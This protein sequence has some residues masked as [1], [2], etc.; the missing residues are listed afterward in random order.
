[1]V[2]L[3][4]CG[5]SSARVAGGSTVA[6]GDEPAGAPLGTWFSSGCHDARGAPVSLKGSVVRLIKRADGRV[7]LVEMRPAYDSI[8]V[9]NSFVSSGE[10]VFQLALKSS[11]SAPYLRE[12]RLPVGASGPGRFVIV[13]WDWESREAESGFRASYAKPAVD[14][15]LIP[16]ERGSIYGVSS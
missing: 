3:S 4:I 7:V 12:Y 2:L 13:S 10:I 5:C 8:V 15:A 16:Q 1:M 6:I 9:V 14:C 11:S